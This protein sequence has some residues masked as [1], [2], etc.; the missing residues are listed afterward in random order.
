MRWP[1]LTAS[2]GPAAAPAADRPKTAADTAAEAPGSVA[3]IAPRG[4][5]P[6]SFAEP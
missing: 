1:P 6:E 2:T 3:G 4:E 5:L